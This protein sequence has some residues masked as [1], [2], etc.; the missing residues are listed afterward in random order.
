MKRASNYRTSIPAV[1][2]ATIGA[3]CGLLP[4][5]SFANDASIS[6]TANGSTITLTASGNRFAG[7]ISSLT[8]RGVEYIDIADHGR[9]M[10]SAIQLDG[11]GECYNPNEAGSRA[12]GKKL[13]SQSSLQYI[14]SVSNLLETRTRPAF[15]LAPGQAYEGAC[16][17]NLAP[18]RNTISTAQNTTVLS[19]FI[20]QRISSFFGSSIPNVIDV[21]VQWT[22]PEAFNSS[23]TEASTAYLPASFGTVL[24]YDR[25]TRKLTKVTATAVDSSSQHTALPVIL[26]QSNGLHAMGAWSPAIMTNPSRGYMAYLNFSAAVDP[27]M[28]W[29]CVFGERNIAAGSTY[30]YSCPIA[31]GTVDEVINAINA[32]PVPGQTLGNMVPVYRFHKAPK[33]FMTRSYSEGASEG[34]T[35]ETTGFRLFPSN[36]VGR[37]ALYRCHNVASS[38][39]FISKNSNCEGQNDEGIIG[40]AATAQSSGLYPLYRFYRADIANHLITVNYSEGSQGGYTYESILGYVAR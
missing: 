1:L 4:S 39:H 30:S 26:A 27:T 34:F 33:H 29:S 14:S 3:L 6:R 7:S 21:D 25:A 18:P 22:I 10:Q 23:N 37:R 32:Y 24:T 15:W 16:N 8:Y 5:T 38:D 31:V 28:K 36:A 17:P 20:V 2:T 13:T 11:L 35:F 40:Y 12:D 9:Q 19:D